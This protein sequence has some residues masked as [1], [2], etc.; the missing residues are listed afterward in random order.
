MIMRVVAM[1]KNLFIVMVLFNFSYGSNLA[2]GADLTQDDLDNI[3]KIENYLNSITTLK[4]I[5]CRRLA[6]GNA[7]AGF[8][9]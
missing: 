8:Y 9:S 7:L 4:S 5:F 3:S 1:L 6:R 2:R